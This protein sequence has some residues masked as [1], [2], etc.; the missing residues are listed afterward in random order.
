MRARG[1]LAA[2]YPCPRPAQRKSILSAE[3]VRKNQEVLLMQMF[4]HARWLLLTLLL[5]LIPASIH[6]QVVFSVGFAPPEMPSYEQPYCPE[7]NMMWMPGYWA[8]DQDQGDYYWV[9][10]A[11]VS[12]PYDGA[13]WTPPYWGWLGG[14]Y[15]FHSGYWGRHVGYYGGVDYGYGYGGIGYSGGEWQGNDFRYNTAITRVDQNR[16][17]STYSDRTIVQRNTI[18]NN[19]RVAYS[20]GPGGIQHTANAQEQVAARDKHTAP[21]SFQTQHATASRSDKTSFAKTNGGHPQNVVAAKPLGPQRTTPATG[22]KAELKAGP[23]SHAA[24]A[25]H[26]T[27]AQQ[28]NTPAQQ[29]NAPAQ[30]AAPAAQHATPAHQ[31]TA[32]QQQARPA[33]QQQARPAPQQQARPAPQQQARPAP[34]QQSRPAPQQQS[35]P[36]PQQQ[37]RPAPQQQAR[38]A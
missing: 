32:Q 20:G 28:H 18:A 38:P 30:H 14:H 22:P 34:Q 35:R 33:P 31:H 23:Q 2:K 26:N 1:T 5:A 3:Q 17:H 19:N 12:A 13:L 10:G 36:A 7:P 21:T 11:W 25:Q 16:I 4:R 37:A 8:Y 6:A 29:H 27:P 24:T 15:R 9:P